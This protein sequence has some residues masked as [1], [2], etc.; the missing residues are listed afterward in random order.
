MY[1]GFLWGRLKETGRF[2]D[3]GTNGKIILKW[4]LKNRNKYRGLDLCGSGWGKVS[5]GGG[6]KSVVAYLVV[7]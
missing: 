7:R 6:C 1:T 5:G 2:E 4:I 3:I